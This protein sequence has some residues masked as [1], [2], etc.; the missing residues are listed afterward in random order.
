MAGY[1]LSDRFGYTLHTS[2]TLAAT[3]ATTM[4][5]APA[6]GSAIA[7]DK[8]R[9]VFRA[10]TSGR[11]EVWLGPTTTVAGAIGLVSGNLT[12]STGDLSAGFNNTYDP[13]SILATATA[14]LAVLTHTAA[15]TPGAIVEV[16]YRIIT[17]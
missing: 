8:V 4:V 16:D 6:A 15:S 9:V 11:S 3:G 7:I 17:R 12:L 2:S 1:D 10:D 14:L 13:P 5:A